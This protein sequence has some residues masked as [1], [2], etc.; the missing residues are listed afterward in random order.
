[1]VVSKQDLVE[2]VHIAGIVAII[3][4][5]FAVNCDNK[6][7]AEVLTEVLNDIKLY[8]EPTTSNEVH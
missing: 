1:M 3:D 4:H 6:D 2:A 7:K 8:L 5:K